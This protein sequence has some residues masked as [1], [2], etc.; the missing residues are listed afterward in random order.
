MATIL[1]I[2]GKALPPFLS[3]SKGNHL[4]AQT[5]ILAI[6]DQAHTFGI[7]RDARIAPRG[8]HM[9]FKLEEVKNLRDMAD[10]YDKIAPNKLIRTGCL[11]KSSESDVST[12]LVFALLFLRRVRL[13]RLCLAL[14]ACEPCSARLALC[15]ACLMTTSHYLHSTL[16]N[17]N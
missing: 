8:L 11:S 4:L 13:A 17:S 6:I 16:L 1:L 7:G 10:A 15:F 12:S 9:A 2:L 3:S 14:P 5:G